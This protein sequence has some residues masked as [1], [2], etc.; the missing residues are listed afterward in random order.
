MISSF[1]FNNIENH[2]SLND[3]IR[4]ALL[5]DEFVNEGNK[6]IPKS[7]HNLLDN[8]KPFSSELAEVNLLEYLSI[9][10]IHSI[11]EAYW[12]KVNYRNRSKRSF[13]NSYKT[14]TLL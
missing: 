2:K 11:D 4:S 8:G 12:L 10:N 6:V 5:Y 1:H 7:L 13:L 3:N 14:A 9:H